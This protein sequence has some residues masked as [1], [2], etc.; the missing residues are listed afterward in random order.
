MGTRRW[1]VEMLKAWYHDEQTQWTSAANLLK[2]VVSRGCDSAKLQSTF[3]KNP[4]GRSCIIMVRLHVHMDSAV[5]RVAAAL[6]GVAVPICDENRKQREV[7][8]PTAH[9][10][11]ISKRGDC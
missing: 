4:G 10:L 2:C 9:C 11:W 6:L 1:Q 8:S 7:R 5:G 3:D